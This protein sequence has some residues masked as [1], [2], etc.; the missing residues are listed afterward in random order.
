[1]LHK[2]IG[3][4]MNSLFKTSISSA[5]LD[6]YFKINKNEFPLRFKTSIFLQESMA[7]E[8]IFF[9]HLIPEKYIAAVFN[10]LVYEEAHYKSA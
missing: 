10:Y 2:Q 3:F 1:M 9:I 4:N 8:W 6:S 5:C 7:S